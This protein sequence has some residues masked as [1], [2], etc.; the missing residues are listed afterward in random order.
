METALIVLLLI[1]LVGA[2]GTAAYLLNDVRRS[3]RFRELETGSGEAVHAELGKR[4]QSEI[5]VL[6]AEARSS[7]TEIEREL[8]RL[9]E[10]LRSSTHEHHTHLTKMRDRYLEV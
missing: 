7:V 5:E 2:T 10:T 3:I 4:F 8:D 1:L 9:R 6:R